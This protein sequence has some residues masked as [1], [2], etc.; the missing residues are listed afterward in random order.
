VLR[1]LAQSFE[2]A[3]VGS[4]SLGNG[5][6]ESV[7][8]LTSEM[9][10][11]GI[12]FAAPVLVLLFL[13]SVLIALLARAVPHVHVME[14]GFTL[15]IATGLLALVVCAPLLAPALGKLYAALGDG[16]EGML[17]AIGGP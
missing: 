7:L 13:S 1:A 2:C 11:A 6:A 3:P 4:L 16:L 15:R 14:I 9:F 5:L 8:Q 10:A 17:S 12:T